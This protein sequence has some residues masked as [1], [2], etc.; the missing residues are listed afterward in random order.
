MVK[1]VIRGQSQ[2]ISKEEAKR[3]FFLFRRSLVRS[4]SQ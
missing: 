3:S 4:A 1:I 2:S